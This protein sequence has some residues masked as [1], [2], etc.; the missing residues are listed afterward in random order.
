[1]NKRDILIGVGKELALIKKNATKEE[2]SKLDP[3]SFDAGNNCIYEQLTGDYSSS[4]AKQICPKS[5]DDYISDFNDDDFDEG[6][7][8]TYLEKYLYYDVIHQETDIPKRII[9]FLKGQ[10]SSVKLTFGS[11]S[12]MVYSDDDSSDSFE[13]RRPKL[14]EI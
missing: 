8:A 13:M 9:H 6:T 10:T 14:V 4:R 12:L 7:Y 1:M 5:F 11:E 3:E 2:L